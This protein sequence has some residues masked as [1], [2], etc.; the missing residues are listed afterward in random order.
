MDNQYYDID[1]EN[2]TTDYDD[3]IFIEWDNIV[4]T[5]LTLIIKNSDGFNITSE[6]IFDKFK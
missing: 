3:N 5:N 2:I 1:H 6:Q 4:L